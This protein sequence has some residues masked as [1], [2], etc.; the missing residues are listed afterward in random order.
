MMYNMAIINKK[1]IWF[2][3]LFIKKI[4]SVLVKKDLIN[5]T[6]KSKAIIEKLPF[7]ENI[8]ICV[9]ENEISNIDVTNLS[10]FISQY[11]KRILTT[12]NM[13]PNKEITLEEIYELSDN[14]KNNKNY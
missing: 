9:D 11:K 2:W 10:Y 7:Y 6:K 13:I 14:K 5:K 8:N 1:N 12:I 3:D 4:S